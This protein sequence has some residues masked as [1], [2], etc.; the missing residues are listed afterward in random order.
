MIAIIIGAS[1]AF[2]RAY[3]SSLQPSGS[4]RRI[5]AFVEGNSAK[6]VQCAC[7]IVK[8]NLVPGSSFPPTNE[9]VA[10]PIAVELSY[11]IIDRKGQSKKTV[12]R[13]YRI[14][15]TVYNQS[16]VDKYKAKLFL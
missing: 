2:G 1:S 16:S 7:A 14:I 8:S 12:E 6:S 9:L 4:Y 10:G 3:R 13:E 15:P 11:V 5:R